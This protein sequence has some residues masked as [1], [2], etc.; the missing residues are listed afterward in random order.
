MRNSFV[1]V[2]KKRTQAIKIIRIKYQKQFKSE[3][4]EIIEFINTQINQYHN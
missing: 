2:R 4:E 3:A 1:V